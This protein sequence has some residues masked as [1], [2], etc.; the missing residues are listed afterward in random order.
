MIILLMKDLRSF[1]VVS[2]FR[3]KSLQT[4]KIVHSYSQVILLVF[5]ILVKL[6]GVLVSCCF[7]IGS[8]VEFCGVYLCCCFFSVVVCLETSG[9]MVVIVSGINQG[10]QQTDEYQDQQIRVINDSKVWYF[11]EMAR[12]MNA[13]VW[14]MDFFMRNFYGYDVL[15]LLQ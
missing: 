7:W 9:L 10:Q 3:T 1:R 6:R 5:T 11:S 14:R 2:A 15:L 12:N 4:T 8:H 13:F